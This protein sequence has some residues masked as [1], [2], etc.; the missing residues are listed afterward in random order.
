M[1]WRSGPMKDVVSCDK[2]WGAANRLRSMDVRMGK[3]GRG[4]ALS[5]TDEHIVG[6]EVSE[7]IE[8]S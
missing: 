6:V 1:P 8:P 7:G 2:P 5:P 3:P 4:N